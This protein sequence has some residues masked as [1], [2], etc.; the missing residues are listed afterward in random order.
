MFPQKDNKRKESNVVL[1]KK[2]IL[3]NKPLGER[4]RDYRWI[5]NEFSINRMDYL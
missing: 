3:K 2:I 4:K 1:M 5:A